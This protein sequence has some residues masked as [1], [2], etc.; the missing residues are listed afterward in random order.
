MARATVALLFSDIEGST[1]LLQQLG[2]AYADL[3]FEHRRVLRQA[4]ADHDGEERGTE[5]D[6]FFV[7]FPTAAAATAAALAG[8]RG[9]ADVRGADGAGVKVRMGLHVGAV[10]VI[11]DTV[12]GL[13]VHEAARISSAAHGGQVLASEAMARMAEP[14]PAGAD[15]VDLGRH[16]LKD[17]GDPMSLRQL[18]H[19]DLHR[20]FPPP[21]SSGGG[22][23]NLPAQPTAFV[24]RLPEIAAVESLLGS[25]RLVTITGAGGVGKSRIALRV[26]SGQ[27]DRYSDGVWLVELATAG[28]AASVEAQVAT[29]L[30]LG[31]VSSDELVKQLRDRR[32]L[33]LLDNCEHVVDAV[34]RLVDAVLLQCRD[35]SIL[36]TSREPLGIDGEAVWR[37]PPLEIDDAI[38]LL[39]VRAKAVASSFAISDDNRAS[40]REVCERLDAIPLALELAAARLGSLTV[41]QL[42]SRL[43]QR[44][45]LLS[46]GGRR[47]L[48][49]HRTLQATVDWSYDLLTAEERT[50]LRRVSVF[51]GGFGLDAAEI[52]CGGDDQVDVF[53]V[54]DRLVQKSL[55]IAEERSW[56]MRYRLLETVRQYGV[57]RLVEAGEAV[58]ARD[59]HLAAIV[60]LA[61]EAEP[62]LWDGGDEAKWLEQLDDAD[63]NIRSAL[64]WALESDNPGAAAWI[65][66]GVFGWITGRGRAGEGLEMSRRILA[67]GV[68]GVDLALTN[69]LVMCFESNIGPFAP[70]T[71]EAVRETAP[72]LEQSRRPWLHQEALAYTIAWSY[73]PGDAEAAAACIEPIRAVIDDVR[74]Y[75]VGVVTW[76]LQPLIWVN[77][78]AGKLADARAAADEGLSNA[79]ASGL[80]LRVS[81]MALNRARISMAEEDLDGAWR[82]AEQSATAARSTGET[83]VVSVATQLLADVAD[84]RGDHALA[85]D[86]LVSILDLVEDS[87]PLAAVEKLRE[88]IAT[89]S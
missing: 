8:Q 62:I 44:F 85:R 26:A 68:A 37:V 25:S 39:E 3:L 34:A 6:S 48:E 61:A 42:A 41:Q 49:R 1:R 35:I 55:V 67:S 12:V 23:D 15:W 20:D 38:E 45:R 57:D 32:M 64:D 4:F 69:F 83:F 46:G 56:G 40:V 59:A 58:D 73:P 72:L 88:R 71:I 81:R 28:E 53:D 9:L 80:S 74:K 75:G 87:Q 82:Y 60:Q 13:A 51:Y 86:L 70:A 76:C 7:T 47:T 30:S 78:D 65:L 66:F 36:A 89:Y 21:R 31:Q 10:D 14:M 17:V 79:L 33:L 50:V 54:I 18:S 84:R 43:D 29:T 22:R 24:G 2:P 16:R 63:G 27:V 11:A 5:G 52:V 19:P 77:L